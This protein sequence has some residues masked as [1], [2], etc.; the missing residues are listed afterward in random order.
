MKKLFGTVFATLEEAWCGLLRERAHKEGKSTSK[1]IRDAIIAHLSKRTKM[2]QEQALDV[3]GEALGSK[4]ED[5]LW[6]GL[7]DGADSEWGY[8]EQLV[9]DIGVACVEWIARKEG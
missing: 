5:I 8:D 4:V 3:I 6:D 9:L 2:T 7:P 1:V